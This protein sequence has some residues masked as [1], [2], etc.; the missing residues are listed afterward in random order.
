MMSPHPPDSLRRD[1][2]KAWRAIVFALSWMKNGFVQVM[3][4][5]KRMGG[6]NSTAEKERQKGI[7]RE[8]RGLPNQ[9]DGTGD[10]RPQDEK[11]E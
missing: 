2:R 11:S 1:P 8:I 9:P 4:L 3:H 7:R 10:P 6:E 5:D